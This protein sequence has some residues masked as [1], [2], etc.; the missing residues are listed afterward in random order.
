MVLDI[1]ITTGKRRIWDT[2]HDT[3][4]NTVLTRVVSPVLS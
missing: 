3:I 2:T 1:I 4:V